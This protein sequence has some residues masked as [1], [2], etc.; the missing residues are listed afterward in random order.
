MSWFLGSVG[1]KQTI[2]QRFHIKII[3]R[4]IFIFKISIHMFLQFQP[5]LQKQNIKQ[6]AWLQSTCSTYS[7]DIK[8]AKFGRVELKL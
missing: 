1:S 8:F 5:I 2:L 4:I 6:S 7:I 3:S